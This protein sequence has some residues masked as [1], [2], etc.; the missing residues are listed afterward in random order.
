MYPEPTDEELVALLKKNDSVAL[1]TLFNRYYKILCQFCSLYTKDYSAAEEIIADLFIKVWDNRKSNIILNVKNYLFVS[2]KNLSIN[3]QQKKK[4]P[5]DSIEDLDLAQHFLQERDT[6]F[7]ILSGRESYGITLKMIDRLPQRQREVL[8]MSR[9][10]NL[11]KHKIAAILGI[12]VRTVETTLYQALAQLR[13][14]L[15]NARNY[16]LGS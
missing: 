3:Y 13:E 8:L 6:P 7:K 11:D 10:D 5:V 14:L 15:K 2:A 9:M 16:T 1:E 4:E 12:S